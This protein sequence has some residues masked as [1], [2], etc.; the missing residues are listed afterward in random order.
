MTPAA[1][2]SAAIALLDQVFA[3]QSAEHALTRWARGARFAGSK[4]RAA[5]RDHVFQALRCKRSYASLG[6][7]VSGRQ[8]MLGAL[9]DQGLDP[10][11]IFTGEGHA[12]PPLSTQE[13]ELGHAPQS[14]EEKADLPDWLWA[15]FKEDLGAAALEA[16][17][18]QRHR[19]PISLRVN[20]RKGTRSQAAEILSEDGIQT[21]SDELVPTALHVTE[22]ERRIRAS[23]AYLDGAVELQDTSSQ[24]A[25]AQISV[26]PG[27]RVLDYC[28]G[29]GG[30]TLALAA[31]HEAQWF[32]HDA[33]PG[34]M[35]D[36]PDRAR[37][38]G[39]C[40]QRLG[41]EKVA[42][43]GGFDVVLCDVP[44][45]GSGTWRRAPEAKWRLT[46]ARLAELI[47]IQTEILNMAS[48]LVVSGGHLIYTT[49]SVLRR[50]N[51]AQ[52]ADFL[53][54]NTDWR[55]MTKNHWPVRPSGDGFF[56]AHLFRGQESE[57]QP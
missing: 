35:V 57:L 23:K 30:K 15:V 29:G 6:G 3:G 43:A 49:C 55:C 56:A 33:D 16:A 5:I 14:L 48:R 12:P 28:A 52:I 40:V 34:R 36:L 41:G 37:R 17:T 39:V 4:D 32:A 45:S 25:M 10:A 54:C 21:Y 24:A 22:G 51:D 8:V 7:G 9:R 1:R 50:E 53:K 47:E 18:G 46:A 20:T 11:T 2:V 44:C 31:C 42:Q 38:A 13:A 26:P 27:G 19:A